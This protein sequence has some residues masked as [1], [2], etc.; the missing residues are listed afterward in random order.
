MVASTPALDKPQRYGHRGMSHAP[1][2]SPKV[3][4]LLRLLRFQSMAPCTTAAD[5]SVISSSQGY[6]LADIGRYATF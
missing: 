1:P 2:P 4:R 3:P 6:D 5:L